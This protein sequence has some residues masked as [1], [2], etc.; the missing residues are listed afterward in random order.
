MKLVLGSIYLGDSS[1]EMVQL[2]DEERVVEEIPLSSTDTWTAAL[3]NYQSKITE[4]V[5]GFVNQRDVEFLRFLPEVTYVWILSPHVKNLEG[6]A[7]LDRIKT[8]RIE[9]SSA[10]MGVLG[11]LTTLED[12]YIDKW[13]PGA[14]SLFNLPN[15]TRV[16]IQ[17]F[18]FPSLEGMAHWTHLRELWMNGGPLERLDGIP[19]SV[20]ELELSNLKNLRS[21]LPLSSCPHLQKLRL[22]KCRGVS[23]LD[24]I[25]QCTELRILSIV[26]GGTIENL[27]PLRPLK[28]LVHIFMADGTLVLNNG[29]D[30]LYSLPNLR[31]LII[32]KHSGVEP[33]KVLQASPNCQVN[34]VS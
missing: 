28:Q 24:G 4:V 23:S 20:K 11:K 13:R 2:F 34:L 29:V 26:R 10:K 16:A 31:H 9:R 19:S 1:M 25:Q 15:L 27:H 32:S 7:Y 8:L 17:K 12:V 18:G 14:E 6:L 21:L 3:S 30:A 22:E 33:E 5:V